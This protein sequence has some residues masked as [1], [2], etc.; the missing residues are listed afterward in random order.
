MTQSLAQM[1]DD[2]VTILD[3]G[4]AVLPV[5]MVEVVERLKVG[6]G[7]LHALGGIEQQDWE[8]HLH[9]AEARAGTFAI[10]ALQYGDL[11]QVDYDVL[12]DHIRMRV[13]TRRVLLKDR[14]A[15]Q[16]TF[17]SGGWYCMG[18]SAF[19]AGQPFGMC[20][21]HPVEAASEWSRGWRAAQ[22]DKL[23]EGGY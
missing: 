10:S 22:A 21:S 17:D 1:T 6:R 18:R 16:P 20:P 23:T 8:S 13:A 4:R 15:K 3:V 19:N 2:G 14:C 5:S 12:V 9:V 7:L 11:S